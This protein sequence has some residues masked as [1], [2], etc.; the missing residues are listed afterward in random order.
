ME[1]GYTKPIDQSF[2]P[3]GTPESLVSAHNELVAKRKLTLL[4][5]SNA[6]CNPTVRAG[7]L[8]QI[9]F[10]EKDQKRGRWLSTRTVLSHDPDSGLVT[11]PGS[12]GK[13]IHAVVEDVRL[14]ITDD[15]LSA[16]IVESNDKL[17]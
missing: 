12:N 11:V 17:K 3:Q 4:L 14:A 5:R 13:K 16:H 9:Y 6:T 2:L 10:K 15:D 8:V 1:K 7:H